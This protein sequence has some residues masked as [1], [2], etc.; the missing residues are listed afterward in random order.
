MGQ[1][2]SNRGSWKKLGEFFVKRMEAIVIEACKVDMWG[3][4]PKPDALDYVLAAAIVLGPW[5]Y[6]AFMVWG[7]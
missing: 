7:T 6:V 2:F 4:T 5:C 3:D 1:V